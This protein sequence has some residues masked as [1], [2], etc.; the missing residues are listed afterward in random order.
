MNHQRTITTFLTNLRGP[1]AQLSFLG[2]PVVDAVISSGIYGNVSV[3]FAVLSY[4]GTLAITITTDVEACPDGPQLRLLLQEE[5]DAL[6]AQGEA[7]GRGRP[8]RHRLGSPRPIATDQSLIRPRR[9]AMSTTADPVNPPPP[10][11][12]RHVPIG[13]I[14]LI[15]LGSILAVIA[16]APMLGGGFLL[17]A[18]G[19]QRDDDGYFTTSTE[20]FETATPAITSERID[21]GSDRSK[22][23]GVSF[24]DTTVRLQ[25]QST[26][27]QPIFVGIAPQADVDRYLSGVAHAELEGRR[28][29]AVLRPVPLRRRR[30]QGHPSERGVVLGD[31]GRGHRPPVARVEARVGSV[32]ARRD[33]RQRLTRAS[34]WMPRPGRRRRGSS[35]W[36]S[37]LAI[38]G[39]VLAIVGQRAAGRRHRRPGSRQRARPHGQRPVRRDPHPS[40]GAADPAAQPLAVAGEVGPAD[41]AHHRARWPCGSRSRS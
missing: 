10:S 6:V 7:S 25:V 19:T 3:G 33:A 31:V 16:L 1:D 4:A 24:G 38:G 37:G 35:A 13:S 11:G 34:A 36:A 28:S 14:V 15:V 32:G 30:G 17:W 41:P 22:P 18:N 23:G 39:L 20:R 26:S 27:E 21:L 9:F 8:P 5:L 29:A 12:R 2:A 40:G